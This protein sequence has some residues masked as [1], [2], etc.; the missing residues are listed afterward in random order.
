MS[1]CFVAWPQVFYLNMGPNVCRC[2][3]SGLLAN[4][5]SFSSLSPV[6][7]AQAYIPYSCQC[8]LAGVPVFDI[9]RFLKNTECFDPTAILA[10][11]TWQADT[12]CVLAQ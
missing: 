9:H 8:R 3:G 6:R 7:R 1:R 2:W 11:S 10:I 12:Y 4:R 5:R